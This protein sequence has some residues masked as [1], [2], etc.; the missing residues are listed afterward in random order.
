MYG[1]AG[2]APGVVDVAGVAV[3]G[4]E[5]LLGAVG[6][7]LPPPDDPPPQAA[8]SEVQKRIATERAGFM[9]RNY[10]NC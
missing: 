3:D 8:M 9:A 6:D 5:V 1:L 4:V 2:S 7:A 10:T